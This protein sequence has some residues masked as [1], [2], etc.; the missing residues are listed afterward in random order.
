[1]KEKHSDYYNKVLAYCKDIQTGKILAGEYTKKAVKRFLNDIK[2]TSE[3]GFQFIFDEDQFIQVVSFAESLIL[4]DTKKPLKLLSWQ[5]FIYANLF[6]FVYKDNPERRR[7]RTSYSEVARKNGKT[8]AFLYPLIIYDFLDSTSAEAYLVSKD[9]KQ[10]EKSFKETIEVIQENQ[11]LNQLKETGNLNCY[12]GAITMGTSRISFFSSESSAID[13][14]RNS[15]SVIDE[16]WCYDSD[17]IVSAF[18]YG[19]RARLNNLNII[20]TSAGLDIS[21]PCY[22]ENKKAKAILDGT[23]TD[24]SY[25]AIIY[26]YDETDDWKN[27]K[28]FIKANPSLGEFLKEDVLNSD[29]QDALITPSHQPDFKS[30]TCGI[31]TNDVS[32]WIPIER[33]NKA[34]KEIDYSSLE[35]VP[36]FGGLDLS[37]VNDLTAYSLCWFK[38]GNYFYKHRFYIPEATLYERYNNENINFLQW[39]EDGIITLIPGTSIDYDFIFKDIL[40][41]KQRFNIQEIAYDR[42]SANDLITKLNDELPA[43]NYIEFDQRLQNMALPTK[44]YEKLIL[45]E[46]ISD[47]NPAMLWQIS[48]AKIKPDANGNYKPLKDYKASNQRIDGVYSSIMATSRAKANSASAPSAS[49][50]EILNSF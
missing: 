35:K 40:A 18:R 23:L 30:K 43:I 10:A 27:P 24:D 32:S 4:P 2:R 15:L 20:I 49:F 8:S 45:D 3:D 26:A 1:M 16:Y 7:F 11:E 21:S 46:R 38:D 9:E 25:F 5:L 31:W 19:G 13:G 34:I 33:W 37:S 6:G 41:D 28:N 36:C 50:S 44:D 47:P 29:L 14:Y 48:N 42:W 12:S 39:A 17:K 22:A